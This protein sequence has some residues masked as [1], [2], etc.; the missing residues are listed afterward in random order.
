MIA[1]DVPGC[2]EVAR[3]GVDALLV[4]ADDATALAD[5]IARLI[6]DVAL[7]GRYA[8]AARQ[9]AVDEFSN[10]HIAKAIVALYS[11]LAAPTAGGE[12]S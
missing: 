6:Q 10:E 1:T 4:P 5:A 7:R 9:I 3:P 11:K 8:R 2:R 12:R